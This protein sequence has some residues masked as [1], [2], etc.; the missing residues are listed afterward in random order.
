M[1]FAGLINSEETM[2]GLLS[3]GRRIYVHQVTV[4]LS[5]PEGERDDAEYWLR[6]L[7]SGEFEDE[8]ND[9]EVW[10]A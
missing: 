5:A 6:R 9:P 10:I 2:S 7:N 4:Y 3:D 1:E 8:E